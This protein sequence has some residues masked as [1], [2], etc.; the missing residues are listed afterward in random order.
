MLLLL[1]PVGRLYRMSSEFT[2]RSWWHLSCVYSFMLK[3]HV[4]CGFA[5]DSKQSDRIYA[6][7]RHTLFFS[8]EYKFF[9][10]IPLKLWLFYFSSLGFLLKNRVFVH[11]SSV[12]GAYRLNG[13]SVCVIISCVLALNHNAPNSMKPFGIAWRMFVRI[14]NKDPAPEAYSTN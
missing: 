7:I 5:S 4:A 11:L 2:L 6:H 13:S 9:C 8:F 10:D 1:L 14:D 12:R 3:C